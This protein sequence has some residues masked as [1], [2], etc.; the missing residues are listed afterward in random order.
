MTEKPRTEREEFLIAIK[1]SFQEFGFFH[2]TPRHRG[3]YNL[4]VEERENHPKHIDPFSREVTYSDIAAA[5]W[6]LIGEGTLL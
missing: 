2:V 5:G 6:M 3:G 1:N 4:S